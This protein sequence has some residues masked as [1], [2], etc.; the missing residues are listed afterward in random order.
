MCANA[1]WFASKGKDGGRTSGVEDVPLGPEGEPADLKGSR[2]FFLSFYLG[3]E[4]VWCVRPRLLIRI[5][6]CSV[7]RGRVISFLAFLLL[8]VNCFIILVAIKFCFSYVPA[9]CVFSLL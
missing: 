2:D 1:L 9:H 3:I 5:V 4:C 6:K 8:L 7:C